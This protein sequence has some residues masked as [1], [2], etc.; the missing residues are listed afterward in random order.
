[1]LRLIKIFLGLFCAFSSAWGAEEEPLMPFENILKVTLEK[2][3]QIQE[4]VAD[5]EIARQQLERANAALFPSVSAIILAAPIFE[6]RGN[7]LKS[8]SN[9]SNWGPYLNAGVQV[10]QPIYT[11][12]QIGG[13]QKAAEGQIA[14]NTELAE[15][16]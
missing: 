8:T 16:K 1:M 15:M 11:F 7:A 14:A 10:I 4:A 6:E 12:G 9:L 5:I 13:Y 2:N 3:A